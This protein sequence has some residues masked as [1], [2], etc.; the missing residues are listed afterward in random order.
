MADQTLLDFLSGPVMTELAQSMQVKRGLPKVLPDAFYKPSG[1]KSGIDQVKFRRFSGVRTTSPVVHHNSTSPT[2]EVPGDQWIYGTAL[3]TKQNFVLDYAFIQALTSGIPYITTNAMNEFKKRL[4]DFYVG[5][6]N[7]RT[8]AIHQMVLKGIISIKRPTTG[9]A[10][11]GTVEGGQLLNSTVGATETI[12]AGAASAPN[13]FG[14]ASNWTNTSTPVGDWSLAA[15]DIEK[16]LRVARQG[17]IKT[18]NY[19]PTTILY[20]VNIPSYLANNTSMQTYMSRNQKMGFEFAKSNEIPAGTLDF[21]WVPVYNAYFQGYD[22]TLN[23]ICGASDIVI[24]PDP[25]DNWYELV[26]VG[27]MIPT[28]IGQISG[29]IQ[30]LLGSLQ[31]AFGKFAYAAFQGIDPVSLKAITGDY[32]FPAVKTT[33]LQWIATVG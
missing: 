14:T 17:F 32:F 2:V 26:D 3:G 4:E 19:N 23:T 22:G 18:S 24:L 5:T 20:G 12:V 28:G 15:T 6:E 30:T 8:T 33:L 16:S 31:P 13:T 11:N 10:A 9:F 7:F 1:N 29:D 27:T 21:N 25:D